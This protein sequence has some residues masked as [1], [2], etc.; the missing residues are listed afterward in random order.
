[1]QANI[2]LL[3]E[4]EYLKWVVPVDFAGSIF[5]ALSILP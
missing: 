3:D 5:A 1:M 4:S 2:A